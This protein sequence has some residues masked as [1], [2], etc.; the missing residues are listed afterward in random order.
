MQQLV[1]AVR[2]T[3]A[4]N[5]IMLGGLQWASD[6]T[7]WAAHEPRDPDHQLIVSFHTYNFSGCNTAACWNAT[8]APLAR[9]TPVVTGEFGE[10]D[11]ADGYALRYMTWADAHGVS[12]LGWAW[13]ATD[14]G[15]SCSGGPSLIVDYAGRPTP[16]GAGLRDH[17]ASLAG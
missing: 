6:E 9:T 14:S 2:S 3:G 15:W 12:Y 8:L 1:D 11:C 7:G 5:P 16:Y 10:N 17:L 4:A 13:D